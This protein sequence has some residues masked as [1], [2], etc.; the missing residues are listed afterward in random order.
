MLSRLEP[1]T[2]VE[3]FAVGAVSFMIV[4]VTATCVLVA[5]PPAK[6]RAVQAPAAVYAPPPGARPIFVLCDQAPDGE[7]SNCREAPVVGAQRG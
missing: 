5:A 6:P 7:I 3:L 1:L 4:A 2:P